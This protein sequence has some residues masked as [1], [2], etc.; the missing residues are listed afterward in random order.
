ML[1]MAIEDAELSQQDLLTMLIDFSAAFNMIDQ[2]R[3][4]M[5]MYDLGIPTDIIE[6]VKDLYNRATTSYVTDYGPT[7]PIN[8]DRGTLQGDTLSP[9]LFLIY[10]EPLL[11]WLQVGGRGH[12]FGCVPTEK[13][14]E[15]RCN[16]LAYAD[17]LAIL[18]SSRSN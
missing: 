18:A 17:D 8:V 3:L 2:D 4:F 15:T 10:M 13:R 11:R 5:V 9:F 6:V 14:N 16:S 12:T 7:A 1:L